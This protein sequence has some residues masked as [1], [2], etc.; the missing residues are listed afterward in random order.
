M[1][2]RT[3]YHAL[4]AAGLLAATEPVL[5]LGSSAADGPAAPVLPGGHRLRVVHVQPGGNGSAA[6][7]SAVLVRPDGYIA[8]AGDDVADLNQAIEPLFGVQPMAAPMTLPTPFPSGRNR[9]WSTNGCEESMPTISPAS[10]YLTVLNQFYTDT[11]EKTDSLIK[12]MCRIVDA[13]AYPGWIS[14]SV[15][16]GVEKFGTLNFIQWRGREDLETRYAADEFKHH[17]VPIFKEITT[18]VRLMQNEVEL[19]QRHPSLGDV[20]EISPDRGDYTAVDLLGVA[21]AEQDELIAAVG[22]AHEWLVE[23]PGYRSQTVL[24]GIRAR[25]PSGTE[26]N[27]APLGADNDY[28]VVYRQWDS[29]EAFDAFRAVP[30]DQQPAARRATQAVLDRMTTF[31]QWNTYR[32][33][34]TRSAS[35]VAAA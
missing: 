13:A 8:W 16:R 3:A 19:A 10:G 11:A 2:P 29:R 15:H 1:T 28:I 34:H 30:D 18:S 23:T 33:V 22:A 14:S 7:N 20:T 25:G 21:P 12:E 27:L 9:T 26:G 35:P 5:V 32:V 31:R 17:T 24:R 6:R 4:A